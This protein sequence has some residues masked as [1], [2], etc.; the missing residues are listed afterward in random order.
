MKPP[1]CATSSAAP[2]SLRAHS[3]IITGPRRDRARDRLGCGR[4]LAADLRA[5]REG[6]TDFAGYLIGVIWV[7]FQF[8]SRRAAASGKAGLDWCTGW[9]VAQVIG[10]QNLSKLIVSTAIEKARAERA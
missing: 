10:A 9:R 2:G 4:T 6:A 1:A 8:I 7:H 5:Q 3:T